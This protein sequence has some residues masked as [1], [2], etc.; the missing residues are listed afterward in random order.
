MLGDL[1]RDDVHLPVDPKEKV[2]LSG[3]VGQRFPMLLLYDLENE[4]YKERKAYDHIR[5]Q[6]KIGTTV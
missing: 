2:D 1:W 5:T 6:E 3:G 4:Q